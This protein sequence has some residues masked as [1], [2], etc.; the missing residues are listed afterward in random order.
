MRKY[1]GKLLIKPAK[2]SIKR[3]LGNIRE[4]INSNKTAKTAN[5]IRK[6]N[7][8]I[9]GWSNYFRH[10]VAKKAF[11]YV[12]YCMFENLWRWIKRR[13]PTKNAGWRRKKYFRQDGLRGWVFYA[14]RLK[15]SKPKPMDLATA[16]SIPIKRHV[17]IPAAAT[18]YDPT[19]RD[20][21][22]KRKSSSNKMRKL[23][24]K[25][26]AIIGVSAI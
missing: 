11:S 25:A 7:P 14:V 8:K 16:S 6:L 5:L 24:R 13:H 17:K 10:V 12:D 19:Y 4:A 15:N 23:I 21:F 18:P 2:N 3:F 1:K 26:K 22:S 9:I 20:Y